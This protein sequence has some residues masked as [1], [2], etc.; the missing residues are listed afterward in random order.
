MAHRFRQDGYLTR[1]GTITTVN[2]FEMLCV[3][4]AFCIGLIIPFEL[5]AITSKTILVGG[6]YRFID[7]QV[8]SRIYRIAPGFVFQCQFMYARLRI[9]LVMPDIRCSFASTAIL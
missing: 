7:R 3:G 1:H 8:Q 2:G 5:L 9:W 6:L 4:A